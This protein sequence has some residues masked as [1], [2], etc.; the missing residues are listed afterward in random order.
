MSLLTLIQ[1]FAELIW[2]GGQGAAPNPAN[3]TFWNLEMLSVHNVL[4]HDASL[5]RQDAYFGSN[6]LFN[7]TVFEESKSYWHGNIVDA[8]MMSDS[9]TGRQF[10]SRVHNP[11]YTFTEDAEGFSIGEILS[12]FLAFGDKR[13]VT[14][15]ADWLTYWLRE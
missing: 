2:T 3:A 12:L 10:S 7:Q 4:E 6:V 8:K 9:K 14:V 1:S 5:S 15:R 11:T 13:A